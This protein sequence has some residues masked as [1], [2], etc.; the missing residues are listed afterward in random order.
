MRILVLPLSALLGI[1][2]TRLIITNFGQETYAQYGLLVSLGALLPFADLG[3]SAAIMNAVGGSENPS[4]DDHVRQVLITSV[5]VLLCSGAVLLLVDLVITVAG[6]WP[7][8]MGE[9][10]I[11]SSGPAAAAAV[12]AVIA[13]TLPVAFGQRVLTGLGK[14]HITIALLGLQTPIVLVFLLVIIRRGL[15]AGSYLPVIP[16][17]VALLLSLGA[18][19]WAAR[20]IHPAIGA[21]LRQVPRVR[22]VPGGKVLDVAWPMLVQMIALPL[23]MQ[24]DRLVLSHVSTTSQLADYNLAAQMYLP[25][26]QVVTAAGVALWPV[27]ARARA[28]GD[29]RAHSPMP[30]AAGFAAAAAVVCLG[31][32]LISPWLAGV[33]SNHQITLSWGLVVAFS[34]FMVCQAAKYPLGMFMTDAPGLRYQALMIVIMVP[35]NLGLS[36]VLASRYGAVGPI[37]GSTIGVLFFQ[38]VANYVYVRRVLAREAA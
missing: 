30:I 31:I 23:A 22:S 2:C 28:R 32:S 26:W 4:R 33:A 17:L 37:I 7:T 6:W 3:M 10:L 25:V 27:F 36:I 38:V 14:N 20:L 35:I 16:Y 15:G 18:T 19:V 34:L 5:R 8:I 11:P 29:R 9:S 1:V 12:L 24:S 13:M 21:A